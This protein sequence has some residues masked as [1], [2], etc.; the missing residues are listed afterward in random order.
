MTVHPLIMSPNR[1][2]PNVTTATRHSTQM[3]AVRSVVA[4]V[5]PGRITTATTI[6]SGM[7]WIVFA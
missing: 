4:A 2:Q 7:R 6:T 3:L 1:M 5:D